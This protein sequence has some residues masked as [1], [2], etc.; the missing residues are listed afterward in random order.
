MS[1]IGKIFGGVVKSTPLG[2]MLDIGTKLI[3][4]FIPDP[5]AAAAAKLKLLELQQSGALAQLADETGLSQAQAR[6][7]QAEAGSSS[8]FV[9]G[10]RPAIGWTCA[11]AFAWSYA[12]GPILSW[13]AS[14]AGH[15]AA[16]P[17]LDLSGM[18]PVLMGMLGL[19]G[20]HTIEN[21]RGVTHR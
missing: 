20:L 9:A 17:V 18:M 8:L 21:V 16:L 14:A 19:G 13:G 3:D 11:G 1:F 15:P 4:R 12:I 2:S 6:I 10:W 5:A 7:D